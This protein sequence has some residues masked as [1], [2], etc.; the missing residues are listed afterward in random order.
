MIPVHA[1]ETI[2]FT[3]SSSDSLKSVLMPRIGFLLAYAY[4]ISTHVPESTSG[5]S[6]MAIIKSD[7]LIDLRQFS[8]TRSKN[9][10]CPE[11][12]AEYS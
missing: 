9:L 10:G 1:F 5:P 11:I 8:K 12:L 6:N 3:P 4:P 7:F 2:K